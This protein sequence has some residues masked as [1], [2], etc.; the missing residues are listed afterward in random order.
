MEEAQAV[1]NRRR[2]PNF[3]FPERAAPALAA[4]LARQKWLKRPQEAPPV[5]DDVDAH[6]AQRALQAGDFAGLLTA[7][8][9]SLPPQRAAKSA[10]EAA[11]AADAIGC[12]VALKLLSPDITHKSDVG[13]VRLNLNDASAVRLAFEAI[14]AAARAAAPDATITGVSVQKM[15][16]NG[17]EVIVGFKR[18]PQFGPL[19]LVGSGGVEV[20]LLRDVAT[21]IAPLTRSQAEG[22]LDST[23]AGK[24]LKG[25]RSLP[26]A[27]RTAVVDVMLR[28]A[29][30]A[31][32][33]P[34]ISELEIF[35]MP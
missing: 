17:Q 25:W 29:Q 7:Y 13:G 2:L 14:I 19:I 28:M 20:E 27:D 18:D 15:L 33:F 26:P 6:T 9:V 30:I 23:F 1:M 4:M 5:F 11:Q 8:G 35:L 31:Q 22:L 10:A 16:R 24:R 32:D 21:G 12:P 34:E 3:A